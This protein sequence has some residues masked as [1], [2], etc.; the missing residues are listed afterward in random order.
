VRLTTPIS[1][2]VL[3]IHEDAAYGVDE[4]RDECDVMIVADEVVES[5]DTL[6]VVGGVKGW[7]CTVM[8]HV[9]EEVI[10]CDDEPFG[11][12]AR[13]DCMFRCLHEGVAKTT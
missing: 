3:F 13:Q 4:C 12:S 1:I 2:G 8:E 11:A 5:R 6:C 7:E 10:A 9:V